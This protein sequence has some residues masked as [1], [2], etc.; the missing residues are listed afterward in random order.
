M[1]RAGFVLAGVLFLS[2]PVAGAELPPVAREISPCEMAKT[3]SALYY[4]RTSGR[5]GE[6]RGASVLEDKLRAYGVHHARHEMRAYL[7]W[8]GAATLEAVTREALPLHAITH[9]FAAKTPPE[10]VTAEA[11]FL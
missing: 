9:A 11:L 1:Q 7:S 2:N 5:E 4:D 6:R 8:P 3:L 10:G